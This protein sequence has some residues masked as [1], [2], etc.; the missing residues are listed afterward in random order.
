M[1]IL[2]PEKKGLFNIKDSLERTLLH[3]GFHMQSGLLVLNNN[4][5][6][7]SAKEKQAGCT[8]TA[9]MIDGKLVTINS[10]TQ[11]ALA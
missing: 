8:P 10:Q 1:L 2:K 3:L 6:D 9:R 11:T 5:C 7:L 4:R